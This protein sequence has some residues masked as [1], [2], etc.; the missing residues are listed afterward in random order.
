MAVILGLIANY[1]N[2]N[3]RER[4]RNERKC[5]SEARRPSK[6]LPFIID[7]V[8]HDADSAITQ[9][10]RHSQLYAVLSSIFTLNDNI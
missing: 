1:G 2:Q 5:R 6:R 9:N 3:Q 7:L 10:K 8:R 4:E